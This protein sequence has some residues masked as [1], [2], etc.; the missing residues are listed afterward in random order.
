VRFTAEHLAAV[1]GGSRVGPHVEVAGL[2]IDSRSDVRGRLFVPI[3]A[4]RDGHD[5]ILGAL[6]AGAAAYL[7]DR[8]PI[9]GTDGGTAIVVG[10][11]SR[12]LADIGS[13]ARLRLP[14]RV[15]GVT[16]SVGKTTV[17]DL[18]AGV[19]TVRYRVAASERSFN[20]ELGVPLT[21]ANASDD[22]EVIVVEMGA[23]G[24]GHV[25]ALCAIARPTIGIVTAVGHGHTALFGTREDV[26]RGKGELVEALS[27]DGVAVLN[28]DDVLVRAMAGR[29]RASVLFVGR[30]RADITAEHVTIGDD[31]QA[32]FVL[33][34]PFGSAQV[35]L[36]ARGAHQVVNA[37]AAAGAAFAV[38]L[39][40]EEVA[41]GLARAT[42]SPW[43]MELVR[44]Q[45]GALVLNDSYNA[46]PLSMA[47]ALHA[48]A[49]LPA[50]RRIAVLGTMAELG[51]IAEAEHR[52][53]AQLARELGVRV[54]AVDEV[55]YGAELARDVEHALEL[56]GPIGEG[57]AVLVKGSRVAGLDR[58]A[59]SLVD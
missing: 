50:R 43:R 57:D 40:P 46:N 41:V 44:A 59:A 19:L 51:P 35:H 53:A 32:S 15:I 13:A 25:A 26:A 7:T 4:A 52:A 20:N 29:T 10:D 56:L 42:P 8:E 17:K 28:G 30:D 16:G 45:S 55:R 11:T 9:A 12:A 24:A 36:A 47:A 14:D 58:L 27:P 49:G 2:A 33:R 21:L 22:A 34:S 1:T 39:D 38:G 18:L 31:L 37:L 6:E 3:L 23:R 54:I 5:F 48:I